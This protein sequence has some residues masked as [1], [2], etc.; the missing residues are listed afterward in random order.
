MLHL[1]DGT[2]CAWPSPNPFRRVNASFSNENCSRNGLCSLYEQKC[3]FVEIKAGTGW[4]SE[5]VAAQI[6]HSRLA[7][8]RAR[9]CSVAGPG[10]GPMRVQEHVIPRSDYIYDICV[11]SVWCVTHI[12]IAV[13]TAS[14]A[15]NNFNKI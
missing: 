13:Q 10:P 8:P 15:Y 14:C 5:R 4:H 6:R 9:T 3:F 12:L 7:M 1:K 11:A 2:G